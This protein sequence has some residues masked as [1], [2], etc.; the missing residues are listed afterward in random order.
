M[1]ASRSGCSKACMGASTGRSR[2]LGVKRSAKLALLAISRS[3][4][5]RCG[6]SV[7]S[8]RPA[9]ATMSTLDDPTRALVALAAAIATGRSSLIL[10]RSR[11]AIGAAVPTLWV[12]ELLLQSVLMVGYPRA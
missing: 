4:D 12:D 9:H 3:F 2:L 5:H 6:I 8:L 7:V 1:G 10:D 11:A